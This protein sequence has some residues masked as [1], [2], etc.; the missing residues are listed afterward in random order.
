MLRSIVRPDRVI[1]TGSGENKVDRDGN[2]LT[3][4]D[5]VQFLTNGI[6]RSRSRIVVNCGTKRVTCRDEEG[7]VTNRAYKNLRLIPRQDISENE[8]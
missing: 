4:G 8:Q 6:F 7:I 5:K 2:A 1:V 3:K